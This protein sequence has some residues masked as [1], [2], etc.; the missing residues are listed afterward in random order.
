L[1]ISSKRTL[2]VD[3]LAAFCAACSGPQVKQQTRCSLFA[4]CKGAPFKMNMNVKPVSDAALPCIFKIGDF[5]RI[6]GTEDTGRVIEV[7]ENEDY[8]I[9][10]RVC[11]F[12]DT[13]TGRDFASGCLEMWSPRTKPLPLPPLDLRKVNERLMKVVA[14]TDLLKDL[15]TAE[16][17]S[18][19]DAGKPGELLS[20][21][22]Q[23]VGS[24]L[25]DTTSDLL[26]MIENEERRLR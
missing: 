3:R 5:V 4:G 25:E 8:P 2:F 9:P 17:N 23:F 10:Y 6:K 20:Y 21:H 14:A 13:N 26:N 7:A 15:A 19:E 11:V 1:I 22:L 12:G 18:N 16:M 24:V